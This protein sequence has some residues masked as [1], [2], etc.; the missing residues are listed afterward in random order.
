MLLNRIG[1]ILPMDVLQEYFPTKSIKH[2]EARLN[3]LL[4]EEQARLD[5]VAAF[6]KREKAIDQDNLLS[7]LPIISKFVSSYHQIFTDYLKAALPQHKVEVKCGPHCGNCCHH[8]PMS[9]SPFEII[10]LYAE[11]RESDAL[12]I[13]MNKCFSRVERFQS[14]LDR[15]GQDHLDEGEGDDPEEKALHD[16]FNEWL[17]CP[18]I[19]E[20]QSCIFYQFRPVTCRMYF[21]ETEPKY[22]VPLHL[23]TTLNRSFIVYL[24][25]DIE[26]S[27]AL[28]SK[29]YENLNLS[30]GLYEGMLQMNALEGKV[31]YGAV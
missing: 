22:C 2:A 1:Y 12:F 21:S 23:Q 31:F 24:P 8:Y 30:E 11:V 15:S 7:E 5:K 17:P 18:F 4:R 28:L 20:D 9:I 26:E 27:I 29:H 6:F 16:F 3:A 25:D 14:L 19:Q 13:H 10:A